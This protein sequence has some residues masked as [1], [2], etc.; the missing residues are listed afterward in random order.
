MSLQISR[1]TKVACVV[2]AHILLYMMGILLA[3]CVT[4]GLLLCKE[5]RRGILGTSAI[6]SSE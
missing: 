4:H 3:C 6:E 5:T 1:N 2:V